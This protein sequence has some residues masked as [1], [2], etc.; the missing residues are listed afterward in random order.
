MRSGNTNFGRCFK[1]KM[2]ANHR[3]IFLVT[4]VLYALFTLS[5]T[6]VTVKAVEPTIFSGT[7]LITLPPFFFLFL[8][9]KFYS[10]SGTQTLHKL[11]F[12]S[13]FYAP[14]WTASPCHWGLVTNLN[15]TYILLCP[16]VS[17]N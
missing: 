17:H 3:E 9:P 6:S 11:C 13:S 4:R 7:W 2:G 14:H 1:E 15:F 8:P 12:I 5:P 16:F 10:F